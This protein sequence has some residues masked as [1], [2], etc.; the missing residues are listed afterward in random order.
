LYAYLDDKVGVQ[1][2]CDTSVF[3]LNFFYAAF[4]LIELAH[5]LCRSTFVSVGSVAQLTFFVDPLLCLVG[6]VMGD[7]CFILE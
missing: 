4:W 6:N 1:H 5:F 2:Q 3:E 7:K